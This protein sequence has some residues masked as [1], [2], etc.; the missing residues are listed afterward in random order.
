LFLKFMYVYIISLMLV[1]CFFYL[2]AS[3]FYY[4]WDKDNVF[5][6]C[7]ESQYLVQKGPVNINHDTI[8]CSLYWR[9]NPIEKS[10]I[11]QSWYVFR[12]YHLIWWFFF[13]QN[14]LWLFFIKLTILMYFVTMKKGI[15]IKLC[16]WCVE[17]LVLFNWF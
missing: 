11:L 6:F 3:R 9:K 13:F 2:S 15:K 1:L 5:W 10:A 12:P 7:V 17:N 16:F 14:E 8:S 4:G